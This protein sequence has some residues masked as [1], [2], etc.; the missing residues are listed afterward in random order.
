MRFSP[1]E[2]SLAAI[3]GLMWNRQSM[4]DDREGVGNI[5]KCSLTPLVIKPILPAD[6]HQHL[7]QISSSV[8]SSQSSVS[9]SPSPSLAPLT[10]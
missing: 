9:P 8:V 5:T 10:L 1:E 3:Q 6:T 4:I 7:H 2:S